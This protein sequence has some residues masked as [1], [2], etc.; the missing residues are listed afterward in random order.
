M[1]EVELSLAK[2]V[3]LFEDKEDS[4]MTSQSIENGTAWTDVIWLESS[5]LSSYLCIL[6]VT[7]RKLCI[8]QA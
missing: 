4:Y 5:D 7:S 2:K 6:E 1:S 3:E 8:F